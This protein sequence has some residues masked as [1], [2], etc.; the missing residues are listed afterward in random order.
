AMAELRQRVPRE[1]AD[2]AAIGL[3]G[4]MHGAVLLDDRGR[5]LRPA[6][7][8]NDVRSGAECAELERRAPD[9]R[10]ITGNLAMPG[11][12][13]PQRLGGA[14][15]EPEVFR[16]TVKILLPKDYLRR[17]LTGDDV[18]EMSDASGTLW[19]DV[20]RRDWSDMMLEACGLAR[21]HMPRL[22]E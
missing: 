1:L 4:Q 17:Q 7:L 20:G 12:P 11:F 13:A 5:V 2:V 21:R 19:L 16:A 10:R 6:I 3:S 18:S 22:V 9:L 14:G 8:W 15:H